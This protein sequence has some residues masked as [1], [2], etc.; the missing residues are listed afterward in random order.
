MIPKKESHRYLFGFVTVYLLFAILYT[1]TLM[2]RKSEK[3]EEFVEA[4]DNE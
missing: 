4:G 1:V 3:L 2:Y